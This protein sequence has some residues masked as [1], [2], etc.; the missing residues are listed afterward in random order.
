MPAEH[1]P[2]L[3]FLQVRCIHLVASCSMT[4]IMFSREISVDRRGIGS[5]FSSETFFI[6]YQSKNE[7]LST[8]Y[9]ASQ[10]SKQVFYLMSYL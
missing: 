1:V 5:T 3:G 2:Q 8:Q 10:L 4:F 6:V 9:F 7:F